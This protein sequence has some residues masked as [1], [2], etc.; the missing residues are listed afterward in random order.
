MRDERFKYV[1]TGLLYFFHDAASYE[2]AAKYQFNASSNGCAAG[3]THEEAI[4]QG[5]LELVERDASAI[6]WYNRLQRAGIDL[7]RLGDSYI[8]DLRTQFAARDASLWMLDVTS[9]ID[10]PV[11]MAVLHWKEEGRERIEFAA[12]A[13][14]DLRVAA[15]RADDRAQSIVG[16]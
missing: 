12:G 1:P 6:W 5:F 16:G 2:T 9:D 4:L 3:N 14:F 10:I 11:V 13:H 7:D 8:R 15:L